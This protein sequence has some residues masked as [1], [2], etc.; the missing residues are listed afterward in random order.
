MNNLERKFR[1]LEIYNAILMIALVVAVASAFQNQHQKFRELDVERLNIVEPDGKL[2]MTISNKELVPDPIVGGRTFTGGR[3]GMKSAGMIF[4]NDKGDECGGMGFAG[5]ETN[6][7]IQA[8]SD[9][10]FDQ[11]NQD[12][13]VGLSY[14]Q[15]GEER[16]SGLQVWDRGNVP[17]TQ[18][19][20]RK[21]KIQAMPA[22]AAK[23]AEEKKFKEEIVRG[24]YG[25]HRLF[26]G[27]A[28][29]GSV[30]VT[31]ADRAGKTRIALE[32]DR[33]NVAHLNFL[34]QSGRVVA[35]FPEQSK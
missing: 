15:S 21:S 10:M 17:L 16:S 7:K 32:V 35:S 26:A 4:F 1:R 3:H 9:F 13:T 12:Q 20:D 34:D 5:N 27:R 24:D 18:L 33:N 2:R 22:G 25:A 11:F 23:D 31:I 28:P 6:G 29:D 19:A 8:S 30:G 14:S